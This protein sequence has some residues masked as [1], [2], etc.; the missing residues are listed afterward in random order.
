MNS[1]LLHNLSYFFLSLTVGVPALSLRPEPA[2]MLQSSRESGDEFK[3]EIENQYSSVLLLNVSEL[4]ISINPLLYLFSLFCL[5]NL[6]PEL[7]SG[8]TFTWQTAACEIGA[9]L[10]GIVIKE[11]KPDTA[12]IM[13]KRQLKNGKPFEARQTDG[14]GKKNT[15]L[16]ICISEWVND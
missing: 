1:F 15:I 3:T 2:D 14:A 12:Q 4:Y 5:Q 7:W 10:L 11:K 6:H 8:K 13:K 9:G 16:Q